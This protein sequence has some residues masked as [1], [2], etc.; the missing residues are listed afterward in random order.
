MYTDATQCMWVVYTV[1]GNWVVLY[2]FNKQI[3]LPCL[4]VYLSILF[5]LLTCAVAAATL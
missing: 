5:F 1:E 4:H 3:F 2:S